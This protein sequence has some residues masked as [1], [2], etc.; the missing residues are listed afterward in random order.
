MLTITEL[1]EKINRHL[2]ELQFTR[3]PQGLYDPVAYVL[4]LG[5]KR[6]RPLL[7]LMAYNLYRED[8][9]RIFPKP[10]ALRCITTIPSCTT[11]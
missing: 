11:T 8:V 5:G 9:E 1:T 3:Q 7:M 4:S 10:R 6:I 2:A